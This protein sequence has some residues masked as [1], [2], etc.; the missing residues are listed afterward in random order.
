MHGNKQIFSI[1]HILEILLFKN[2][3]VEFFKNKQQQMIENESAS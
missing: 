3:L 2:I 1:A